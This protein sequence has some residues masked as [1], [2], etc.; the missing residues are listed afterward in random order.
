M[1]FALEEKYLSNSLIDIVIGCRFGLDL[2]KLRDSIS[3]ASSHISVAK[4]LPLPGIVAV[5]VIWLSKIVVKS[6]ISG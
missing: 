5:V 3:L 2:G 1:E 4:R 6:F